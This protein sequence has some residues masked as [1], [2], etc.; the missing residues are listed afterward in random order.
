MEMQ[1]QDLIAS[2]KKDG[3]D[4]AK[5]EADEYL[6]KARA[7]A[8][9]IVRKAQVEREKLLESAKKEIDLERQSSRASLEQ[10]A[11]DAS[12]TIK[13]SVLDLLESILKESVKAE[14]S[15][16]ALEELICQVVASDAVSDGSAVNV[17]PDDLKTLSSDL[18]AKLAQKLKKGIVLRSSASV[19]GGFVVMEK[20]GSG[21][22]DLSDEEI[23][24]LLW[25]Y[26]SENL[27]KLF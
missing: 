12:L 5:K 19:S 20:D 7:E 15:G 21:F 18:V 10:A 24:K 3:L 6:A 9:E 8:E 22:I 17:S 25:P 23:A 2:I 13:R 14:L 27:R 11:R 26:L 16:K 4:Q 1:I